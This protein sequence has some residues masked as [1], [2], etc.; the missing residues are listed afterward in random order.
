MS[1]RAA[2][3]DAKGCSSTSSVLSV[4]QKLSIKAAI[5][6]RP[7]AVC[8]YSPSCRYADALC[9]CRADLPG[10]STAPPASGHSVSP[11]LAL[12]HG[13]GDC[14]S[15]GGS[16]H[17]HTE[18]AY[19]IVRPPAADSPSDNPNSRSTSA[20]DLPLLA[21]SSTASLLNSLLYVCR[22]VLIVIIASIRSVKDLSL[23]PLK[24]SN[25]KALAGEVLSLRASHFKR[26]NERHI[27]G[28][29]DYNVV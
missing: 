21:A 19:S 2:V 29:F 25:I 3:C 18:S 11:A 10:A 13:C 28:D 12:Q 23:P 17:A 27:K 6:S 4:A 22:V 14:R 5:R 8:A 24:R 20:I 7:P 9:T 26:A 1:Q 15:A 16:L